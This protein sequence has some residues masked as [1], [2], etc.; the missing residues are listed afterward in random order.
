[1]GVRRF[2]GKRCLVAGSGPLALATAARLRDEGGEVSTLAASP[3]L[4]TEPGAASAVA[5]CVAALGALDVLVTA[6]H[7]RED[8]PFLELD[9]ETW[10]RVLDGNLKCAFLVGREA[11]RLMAGGGGG[12]IVHVGSDLGTRPRSG[13]GAFA[14]AKA[15][16]HLLTTCMALDLAPEGVRVCGVAA[17]EDGTETIGGVAFQPEDVAAAVAFCA[18]GEASYVLGSTFHPSGGP[19]GRG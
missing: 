1:M 10:N 4:A 9:D 5:D 7:E 16:V 3:A 18:S 17:P 14:A 13:T 6:F 11:A 15:G 19:P 12:S 2:E 8:R